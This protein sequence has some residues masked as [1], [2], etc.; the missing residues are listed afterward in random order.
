MVGLGAWDGAIVIW[1]LFGALLA[2][3]TFAVGKLKSRG[4]WSETDTRRLPPARPDEA[5]IVTM[6]RWLRSRRA[7]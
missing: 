4:E 7:G 3:N 5:Y 1:L 2:A 6:R